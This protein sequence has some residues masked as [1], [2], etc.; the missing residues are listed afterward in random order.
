[1]FL[2]DCQARLAFDLLGNTW[3]AV[4]LW[5]LRHGPRRPSRLR[6]EVGGISAKVL[7]ETLRRLEFNGLVARD[8]RP[9]RAEYSLTELGRSLLGPIESFGQWAADHADEVLAAQDAA[10]R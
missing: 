6:A 1:M 7:N 2:A 5:S 8:S 10:G 9:G 4:L 3:N